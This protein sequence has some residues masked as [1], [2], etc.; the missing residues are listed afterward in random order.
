MNEKEIIK[1]CVE[2]LR[3]FQPVES[4]SILKEL[5]ILRE[6]GIDAKIQV[7][8]KAGICRY[9]VEIK[10]LLKRPLPAYLFNLSRA[11]GDSLLVMSG[12]INPS[13]AMDLKQAE[14]QYI[15]TAGNAFLRLGEMIHIE[16]KGKKPE[17]MIQPT[18][19]S[20]FQ[21]KLMQML[22]IFL[23]DPNSVNQTVR[24][25]ATRA[26]LSKDRV[27]VGLRLLK[28][29]GWLVRSGK[30]QYRLSEMRTLFDQ[31]L[32]NYG[33]RLRPKLIIGTYKITPSNKDRIEAI[34]TEIFRNK[35][36]LFALTGSHGAD[37]LTHYYRSKTTE[38]FIESKMA[39]MIRKEL[40]LIPSKEP[41][42]TLFNQFSPA[43]VFEKVKEI[44]IAHPLFIYAELL[45]QGGERERETAKMIY[46]RYLREL[47]E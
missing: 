40:K 33:E 6:K 27:S 24:A 20:L 37:W 15:D 7:K 1:K 21:P 17:F 30:G 29:K 3:N 4:V 28:Q 35:E 18:T 11:E 44:S 2:N 47:F 26:G 45:Y 19:G 31:W 38:I 23:I 16:I 41:D 10:S 36:K 46:D 8:F 42:V 32:M 12:Y 34:L 9:S 25:L 43:I 14:I 5:K 13:I 22:A 39:D